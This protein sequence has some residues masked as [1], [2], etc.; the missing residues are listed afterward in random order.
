M[1]KKLVYVCRCEDVTMA[2]LYYWI[3]RGFTTF[4]GL[5]RQLRIGMGPCQGQICGEVVRRE[6]ALYH[7]KHPADV[8]THTIRPLTMGVPLEAIAKRGDRDEG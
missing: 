6:L 1:N 2:E 4:E 3:N 8:K 7:K 5:K